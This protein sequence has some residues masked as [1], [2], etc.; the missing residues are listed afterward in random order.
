M[1]TRDFVQRFR[2]CLDKVPAF[3]YVETFE[4][5][6]YWTTEQGLVLTLR[7]GSIFDVVVRRRQ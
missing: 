5:A 4:E 3:E 1:E 7:D 6:H 2:E